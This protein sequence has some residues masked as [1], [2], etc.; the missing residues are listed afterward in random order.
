[1]NK[2]SKSNPEYQAPQTEILEV[3]VERGFEGS[4]TGT[5]DPDIPHGT[6]GLS[7]SGREYT[8]N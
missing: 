1:M 7:N 8:F 2:T 6:E 3:R 4:G 5:P